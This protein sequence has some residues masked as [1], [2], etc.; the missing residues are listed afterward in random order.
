L[1]VVFSLFLFVFLGSFAFLSVVLSTRIKLG[2]ERNFSGCVTQ[3]NQQKLLSQTPVY[4][5]IV[6]LPRV[7]CPNSRFR[8]GGA[9]Q[10]SP[11]KEL[12][13][14]TDLT[15]S[16]GSGRSQSAL[17]VSCSGGR[18]KRSCQNTCFG[19]SAQRLI[20]TT[21]SLAWQALHQH[22]PASGICF[23]PAPSAPRPYDKRPLDHAYAS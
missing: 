18:G 7:G 3:T 22:S 17:V 21:G 20:I 14:W 23:V 6:N 15:S 1:L 12:K 4:R 9:G 19:L 13:H 10:M 11:G 2:E 5:I 16:T 8:T